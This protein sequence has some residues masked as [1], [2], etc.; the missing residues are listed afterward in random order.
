MVGPGGSY[1]TDGQVRVDSNVVSSPVRELG[2]A[3]T[4]TISYRILSDDGHPVSGKVTLTLTRAGH[5]TPAPPPQQVD[6]REHAD[7]SS[8]GGTPIWP[9][10][11]G[12]GVLVVLGLALSLRLGKRSQ[13]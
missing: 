9:W 1:W 2:P 10:I 6:H 5:G 13:R 12:A 7:S 4:Y 3:G 11:A 8:G